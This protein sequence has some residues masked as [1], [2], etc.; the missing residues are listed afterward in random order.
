M[1]NISVIGSGVAGLTAAAYLAEKGH[2]VTI[3]EQFP[4]I[5]G[6]T[7]TLQQDGFSWDLGPMLLQGF[8]PDEPGGLILKELGIYDQLSLRKEDRGLWFPDYSFWKPQNY[9]GPYWRRE[10]LK[11]LF[12]GE[13]A[14]LDKYYEFYDQILDL[15]ALGSR[16]EKA[17]PLQGIML[18]A[19]AWKIFRRI[20]YTEKWTAEKLMDHFFTSPKLK[21]LYTGILADFVVPPSQF[22]ALGIPAINIESAFDSRIPDQIS[23]AG[24]R[25]SYWYVLGG[26]QNLVN[27]LADKV[28]SCGGKI[29]TD[30]P[31]KKIMVEAGRV[32]GIILEDGT[33]SAADMVI[34]SG[35]VR[36]IMLG[37]V[38]KELLPDEFVKTVNDVPLMESVHMIHLGIDMDPLEFQ[39]STLCYYYG[40]YDVEGAVARCQRGE[41]HE[42]KDGFL[43][44]V[45]S[46]HSPEMAPRGQHA[47][48]IYTIAPNHLNSGS[49][50]ERREELSDTLIKEAEK[51]IPGLKDHTK[52]KVILTPDDFRKRTHLQHHAFGGR[53]PVMG[54]K[55][56]PHQTPIEGLWFIGSQSDKTGGGVWGTM[57]ASQKV[58]RLMES[59][60]FINQ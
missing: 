38:G 49:W 7:A 52:V 43:I 39:P 37:A 56:G 3:F 28:R 57:E 18:R 48:T 51:F 17:G 27:V 25:Q 5:G 45:P 26:C 54:K 13:A 22:P 9:E 8:G 44:Y 35:G 41:Y 31:V 42:G 2:K 11:K 19:W 58:V 14:G 34:S 12:P 36:E 53:A 21:A 32:E 4:E 50:S 40:T 60:G 16:I 55:G 6:V 10:K 33:C 29:H 30:T 59:E 20:K 1:S 47:L 24:P 23:K 46:V 15:M